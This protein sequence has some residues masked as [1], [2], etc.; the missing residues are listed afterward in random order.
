MDK[1]AVSEGGRGLGECS[2]AGRWA[3]GAGLLPCGSCGTGAWRH[4][5]A[6]WTW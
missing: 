2:G 1:E 3:L 5:R 4:G 6:T